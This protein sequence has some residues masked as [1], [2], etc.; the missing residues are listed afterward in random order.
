M[1]TQKTCSQQNN[2][3][4]TPVSIQKF[5]KVKHQT[6]LYNERTFLTEIAVIFKESIV[7]CVKRYH[8]TGPISPVINPCA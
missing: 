3:K 1:H 6:F 7:E 5:F 8:K 2:N 4:K